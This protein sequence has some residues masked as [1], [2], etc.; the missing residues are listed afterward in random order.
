MS[1]K[2]NRLQELLRTEA[3]D[4]NQRLGGGLVELAETLE[5]I[6]IDEL[7]VV[8]D[9]SLTF[10]SAE[11]VAKHILSKDIQIR[12]GDNPKSRTHQLATAM[13]VGNM[14]ETTLIV[15]FPMG[16]GEDEFLATLLASRIMT[17]RHGEK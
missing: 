10:E 14:S 7:P 17:L 15:N 3:E 13:S 11:V 12:G 1:T 2:I 16:I 8:I 5:Q 6:A 4:L 9:D